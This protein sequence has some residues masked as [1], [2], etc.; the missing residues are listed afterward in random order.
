MGR[1]RKVETTVGEQYP[2]ENAPTAIVEADEVQTNSEVAPMQCSLFQRND[3]GLLS[4]IDYKYKENHLIDW[5]AMIRPEHTV[6]NSQY[7]NELEQNLQKRIEDIDVS[8]VDDKHLL[9]LLAGFKE[10]ASIRGYESVTYNVINASP[11]YVGVSCRIVWLPNYES[12][13]RPLTFESL[14]DASPNNTSGFARKYLMAIAENRA[15]VR[16]VRNSL[17]IP[18]VGKDEIGT[19][20][21]DFM[22][23]AKSFNPT[24]PHGVLQSILQE[25]KKSFEKFR[26]EWVSIGHE[27]A[28]VW[29]GLGDIPP[30]Q[31]FS[32]LEAIKRPKK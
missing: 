23:P 19:M 10:L 28:K 5:R 18:I 27:E 32:I 1:P 25:K 21:Q 16:C 7:K 15:F 20:E 6:I 17:G 26:E 22:A 2:E 31:I 30:E 29:T 3:C 24:S 9:I 13:F 14:A 12:G 11:D 4:F 8:D